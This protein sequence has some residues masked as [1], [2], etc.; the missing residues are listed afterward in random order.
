MNPNTQI[1]LDEISRRCVDHD[2]KWNRHVSKQESRW[3]TAFSKFTS[4]QEGLVNALEKATGVLLDDWHMSM[5]DMVYDL[6]ALGA[7]GG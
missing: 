3:D 5:E 7:R 6:E 1:I 4:G 2:A